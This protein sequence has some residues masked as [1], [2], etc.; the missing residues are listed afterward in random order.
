MMAPPASDPPGGLLADHKGPAHVGAVHAVE[1]AE[2]QLGQRRE[3]HDARGVDHH[4]HATELGFDLVEQGRDLGFIGDVGGHHQGA[5]AGCDDLV[6]DCLGAVAVAC[7]VRGDGHASLGEADSHGVAD[8][9]RG[10]GDDG[11]TVGHLNLLR[12]VRCVHIIIKC[13]IRPYISRRRFP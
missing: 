11:N 10:S 12:C 3:Q 2:V 13:T 1:V 6:G 8:A 7:V 5:A 9:A 4:V